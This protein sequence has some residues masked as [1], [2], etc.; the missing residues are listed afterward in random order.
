MQLAQTREIQELRDIFAQADADKDDELTYAEFLR[1]CEDDGRVQESFAR[2]DLPTKQAAEL[3]DILDEH[4]K[5][6]L[7]ID[8]FVNGCLEL[9]RVSK[10]TDILGLVLD[11]RATRSRVDKIHSRVH[12]TRDR[13]ANQ[14]GSIQLGAALRDA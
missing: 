11:V 4:N 2:L 5:G 3:F 10:S 12:D 9:H 6:R 7:H 1:C 14:N 8:E 13:C